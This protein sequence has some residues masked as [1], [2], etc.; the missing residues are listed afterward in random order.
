MVLKD[1]GVRRARVTPDTVEVEFADGEPEAVIERAA[2]EPMPD[3]AVVK[4]VP[5]ATGYGS[6]FGSK[7]PGFA[8]NQSPVNAQ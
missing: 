2:D 1:A 3:R 4:S 5:V 8:K 6:L 7:F